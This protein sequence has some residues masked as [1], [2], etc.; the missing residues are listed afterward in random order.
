M[1]VLGAT[2]GGGW[3]KYQA[4]ATVIASCPAQASSVEEYY[5]LVCPQVGVRGRSD[6]TPSADSGGGVLW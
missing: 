4:V 1:D 3:R 6:H 2:G 5:A